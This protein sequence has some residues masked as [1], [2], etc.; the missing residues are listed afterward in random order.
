M[1][2]IKAVDFSKEIPDI[3]KAMKN[4]LGIK[5]MIKIG[6]KLLL[7][8]D[9]RKAMNENR[10]IFKKY[11]ENIGYGYIIGRKKYNSVKISLK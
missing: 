2:E 6:W 9:L 11:G 10:K 4:E 3:G 8:S 7:H 5:G 1:I